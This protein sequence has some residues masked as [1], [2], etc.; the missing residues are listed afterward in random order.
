MN[1]EAN[2]NFIEKLISNGHNLL[3][4]IIDDDQQKQNKFSKINLETKAEN[5][6]KLGAHWNIAR[7]S[8]SKWI[9]LETKTKQ[10]ST[11]NWNIDHQTLQ[12]LFLRKKKQFSV[13]I[14][15]HKLLK[16]KNGK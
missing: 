13:S 14:V 12:S 11:G 7:N 3:V 16:K 4:A 10:K 6:I 1:N 8:I 5:V 15:W 2:S 9:Q